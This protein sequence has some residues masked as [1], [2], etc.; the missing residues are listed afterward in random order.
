MSIRP[1]PSPLSLSADAD[2]PQSIW[3][4][5][6]DPSPS[7]TVHCMQLKLTLYVIQYIFY[8]I[9]SAF[10][11]CILQQYILRS[12]WSQRVKWL[13]SPIVCFVTHIVCL[14]MQYTYI[15]ETRTEVRHNNTLL[16]PSSLPLFF[17]ARS[18]L[19]WLS[20]T[21]VPWKFQVET[22]LK[23][24]MKMLWERH[25]KQ[26]RKICVLLHSHFHL[27]NVNTFICTPPRL[28]GKIYP[29]TGC[30]H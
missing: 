15:A 3:T 5:Q 21:K 18:F 4:A 9:T 13:W 23:I 11:N 7:Q 6:S 24:G 19:I 1:S 2:P 16:L 14:R 27:Q 8:I 12:L 17:L 30:R 20:T 10:T 28:F 22:N 25:D 26:E 29:Y